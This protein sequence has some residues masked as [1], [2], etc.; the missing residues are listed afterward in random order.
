M[1]DY[2]EKRSEEEISMFTDLAVE[3]RRA[4]T[5]VKGVKYEK[6]KTRGGTWETVHITSEAGEK[7]IGRPKGIY[8]T[9]N[10]E[11]MD[12]LDEDECEDATDEIAR[13]LCE[14]CDSDRI[15]PARILV[16]GLGNRE[17][18]PDSVGPKS[19]DRVTATMQIMNCDEEHFD[20]LEC[21]EIAV[22][23]PGVSAKSGL[24]AADWVMGISD[25]L[26]P[27]VIFAIDA[28]ASRAPARLG[29]TVQISNTGIFPGSGV[30]NARAEISK[31]KLGIP[32]IA[33][34]VPTVMDSRHFS[35]DG[36]ITGEPMF[37]SPREI[38]GIV[39]SAAKIIGGAINQ[40]FGL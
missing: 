31:R 29:R 33:I 26:K 7:A 28:L 4:D 10:L 6:K 39:K 25:R 40:A 34:G 8:A 17:L 1:Y 12:D 22:I 32:V 24:D 30:G 11:R 37:V 5:D 23:T 3:R 36:V 35:S 2:F 18:T 19:A 15:V 27:D 16:V 9:L 13:K 20:E 21:S 14:I 38:D